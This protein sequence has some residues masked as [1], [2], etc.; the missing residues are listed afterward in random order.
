MA[1]VTQYVGTDETLLTYELMTTPSPLQVTPASGPSSM[2]IL[3]FVV[4]CPM[5]VGKVAV[6]QIA[7]DLPIG[8]PTQPTSAD[9]SE[10]ATGISPSASASDGSSWQIGPGTSP[11]S[12]VLVPAPGNQGVITT[13]GITVTLVGIAVSPI[14]GAATVTI[15][16]L[17][18]ASGDPSVPRVCRISVPKFPYGITV[19]DF[20]ASAPMVE[21]GQPVT[22]S[23]TGSTGPTYT[24]LYGAVTK[25]VTGHDSYTV[26]ALDVTTTFILQ[27]SA[28]SGGQT[29][30]SYFTLTVVVSNP[31]VTANSLS[32]ATTA[33]FGGAVTANADVS[34]AG[35]I[36]GFGVMP[37]GTV[38]AYGGDATAN[39][40]S[41]VAQGW[42]FCD[43]SAVS[44]TDYPSLFDA[45]GTLHGGGDGSTTFNLPDHRGRFLRGTDHGAG[46]DPDIA[47][48]VAAAAG[49][50]SGD[51]T[52]SVQPGATAR[53][54]NTAMTTDVQGQH[55][56]SINNVPTDNSSYRIAGSSLAKWTTSASQTSAAGEHGH[57]LTGGGDNETRPINAYVDYLI[58]AL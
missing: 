52:G 18:T 40:A 44:R 36:S 56:H 53:A 8:S 39:A 28:Q 37:I 3:T 46:R 58:R 20:T 9:L 29:V 51:S 1:T 12:F 24:L 16:E 5:D 4:S 21:H 25:D 42:L 49:G 54:A 22:V 47:L 13:Q 55:V 11:G 19:N 10:T 2:G 14:V 48:R 57:Y 30:T 27:V 35:T 15:V 17:A 34:V 7:F 6:T 45:I 33:S 32:V 23:W 26:T 41:L 43:G 38:I 31:D 50:A